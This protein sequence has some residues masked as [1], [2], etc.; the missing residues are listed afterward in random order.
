MP[1]VEVLQPVK[2]TQPIDISALDIHEAIAPHEEQSLIGLANMIKNQG[3]IFVEVGIWK[4][5]SASIVGTRVKELNARLYCIDHWKGNEGTSNVYEARDNDIYG[6]FE[7]NMRALEL[8][9][10]ITTLKTDSL[11]ATLQF[12]DNSIDFLFLDADHRYDQFK[13]DLE[14]WTPKLKSGGVICGHDCEVRYSTFAHREILNRNLDRDYDGKYHTGI[15]RGLFDYFADDYTL[16]PRIWFKE[17][18]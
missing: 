17:I 2:E 9:D 8:W 16:I 14:A 5:H 7:H 13:W 15:I 12:Q 10:Y 4:G 11:S 3:A 1:D 18:A 6:I